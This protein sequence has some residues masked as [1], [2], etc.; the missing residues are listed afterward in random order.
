MINPKTAPKKPIAPSF[1]DLYKSFIFNY[2]SVLNESYGGKENGHELMFCIMPDEFVASFEAYANWKH[3][4]G[5]D[6]R[7]TKFSDIGANSTD[8]TLIKNHITDAYHNWAVPPTYVLLVGD[9]GILP[10]YYIKRICKR[11][12]LC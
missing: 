7:I 12:L 3:Q 5:I 4:S 11:K 2:Q 1:G 6:I 10:I 9:D 8:F